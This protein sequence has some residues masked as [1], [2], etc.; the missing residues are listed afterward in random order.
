MKQCTL[1]EALELCK[2][3]GGRAVEIIDRD[4]TKIRSFF[5]KDVDHLKFTLA[6]MKHKWSYEPPKKS[7]FQEWNEKNPLRWDDS[8][9]QRKDGWVGFAESLHKILERTP[10]IP[11]VVFETIE[12][13][14]EP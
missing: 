13:L 8:L 2:N 5:G 9:S 3:F 14:K 12:K 10:N 1:Q 4:D 11:D 7:A 6:E